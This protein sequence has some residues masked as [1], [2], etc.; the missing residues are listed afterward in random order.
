PGHAL[1]LPP[2][3]LHH[4]VQAVGVRAARIPFGPGAHV[5]LNV[6]AN[7]DAVHRLRGPRRPPSD[8]ADR[9]SEP[10]QDL[11]DRA[12]SPEVRGC[13]R[14]ILAGRLGR[15]R[16]RVLLLAL[17]HEE[18]QDAVFLR[19]FPRRDARPDDRALGQGL[20]GAEL[21][22]GALVAHPREVGASALVEK[23]TEHVPFACVDADQEHA[24]ARLLACARAVPGGGAEQERQG[25]RGDETGTGRVGHGGSWGCIP[26]VRLSPYT[27]QAAWSSPVWGSPSG[28]T[29]VS[30]RRRPAPSNE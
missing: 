6:I 18:I 23:G 15:A 28:K 10:A 14:F 20:E 11:P 19:D 5:V 8:D 16:A 13:G 27:V 25:E 22:A 30:T 12:R 7:Q 21:S 3:P 1:G 4:R 24:G 26:G 2:Q 17:L 9:A 29:M